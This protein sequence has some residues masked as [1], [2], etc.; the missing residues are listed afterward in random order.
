[1]FQLRCGII[2]LVHLPPSESP[3]PATKQTGLDSKFCSRVLPK[4]KYKHRHFT[5]LNRVSK[6]FRSDNRD[7][8]RKSKNDA[9]CYERDY[10]MFRCR[11][12]IYDGT[13]LKTL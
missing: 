6:V 13:M 8:L 3:I 1:M 4:I 5:S 11:S 12:D 9:R 7:L 2:I 10:A